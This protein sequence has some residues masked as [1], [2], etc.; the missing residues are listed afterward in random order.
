MTE[1]RHEMSDEEL[2]TRVAAL[3]KHFAAE[4][5]KARA[6]GVRQATPG[7]MTLGSNAFEALSDDAQR[8]LDER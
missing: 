6:P 5:A 7:P 2:A 1:Q 4:A 8:A 3:R